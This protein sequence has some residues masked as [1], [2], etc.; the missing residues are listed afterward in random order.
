M[1]RANAILA[2]VIF[3][4]LSCG[5]DPVQD[6]QIEGLQRV[7]THARTWA[8]RVGL[9]AT[10]EPDL[11]GSV[12]DSTLFDGLLCFSGEDAS[13]EAVKA[14]QGEDGR[15]WR[16]ASHVGDT[17]DRESFSR[18]MSLG[19][20][21]YLVKTKDTAAAS[22]WIQYIDATGRLCPEGDGSN[23]GMTV[24]TWSMFYHVWRYLGLTPTQKMEV[25]KNWQNT[26]AVISLPSSGFGKHLIGVE[27]LI[28]EATGEEKV[29]TSFSLAA[30][31]ENNPF[32]NYLYGDMQKAADLTIRWCP[33]SMPSQ[34][35]DWI[36]QRDS[37]IPEHSSG[38]DCIFMTNLLL[39]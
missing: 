17:T 7:Q 8:E 5:K 18:D 31:G 20:L 14:A 34:R 2:G 21:A 26:L 19:V 35:R 36:W 24:V 27:V 28:L 11:E 12:R 15:F 16:S 4:V 25:N 33:L 39:R 10:T 38:W 22:K 9:S 6:N 23:C 30:L 32:Y 13:C 3:L 1:I 37:I 29:H